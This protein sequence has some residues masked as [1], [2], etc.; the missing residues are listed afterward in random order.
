MP[1]GFTAEI[2]KYDIK[3]YLLVAYTFNFSITKLSCAKI[4]MIL[5]TAEH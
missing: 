5:F 2:F 4:R 3:F 1:M